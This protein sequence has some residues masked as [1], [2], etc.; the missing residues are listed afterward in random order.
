ME[1]NTSKLESQNESQTNC[2]FVDFRKAFDSVDHEVLLQI[3]YHI[4]VRGTSHKLIENYL[5]ERFQYVRIN[6]KSSAMKSIKC[7]VPQG[8]I[9]GPLLFLIDIDDLGTEENWQSEIKE[10]ADDTVL[11]EKLDHKSQD[12]KLL[13]C[14][15]S[16]NGVDCNYM[17]T[18]FTVFEK[19]STKH[20]NIVICDHEISSCEIYKDPGLHLD[21]KHN[22]VTHIKKI[23]SKLAQH[24]GTLYKLRETFNK[25]QLV[26]YIRSYVLPIVHY[27]VLLYG[28]GAK[29]KLQKILLVQKKLIRIALRL[30]PWASVLGKFNELKIG[31]VFEYHI[32]E[33][34]KFALESY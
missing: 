11:I 9:L 4:G 12:G 2:I 5:A 33:L 34:F 23:V 27:G 22:F 24:C 15:M 17:K 19:R 31:T 32:Y 16:R 29:T 26:Q 25:G 13:E 28:F 20:S 10:Y 6:D 18:K 21:Q 7:G 30:P 8:S 14:W 1:T 3:L